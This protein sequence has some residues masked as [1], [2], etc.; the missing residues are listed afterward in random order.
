VIRNKQMRSDEAF[1]CAIAEQ[2]EHLR[3]TPDMVHWLLGDLVIHLCGTPDVTCQRHPFGAT[4][5]DFSD[6]PTQ[7]TRCNA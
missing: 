3:L 2:A 6:A 4:I 5:T 1:D 7:N